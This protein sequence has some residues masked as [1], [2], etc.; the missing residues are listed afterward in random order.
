MAFE[1]AFFFN[2]MNENSNIPLI[3][4]YLHKKISIFFFSLPT[5]P[6]FSIFA[7]LYKQTKICCFQ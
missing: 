6:H 7:D 4:N 5:F 1:A 2:L 3:L